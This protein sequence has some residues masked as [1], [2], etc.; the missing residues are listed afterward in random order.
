MLLQIISILCM[1]KQD[2]AF[3]NLPE[4]IYHENQPT[5]QPINKPTNILC[6][7]QYTGLLCLLV[8]I[9]SLKMCLNYLKHYLDFAMTL[10]SHHT[11]QINIPE[12]TIHY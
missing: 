1:Y 10:S 4:L 5:Y 2:L 9:I 8:W 11:I 12:L 3:N 6:F 7:S